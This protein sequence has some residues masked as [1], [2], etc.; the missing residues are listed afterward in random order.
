MQD[1][2]SLMLT[3]AVEILEQL[4]DSEIDRLYGSALKDGEGN[5]LLLNIKTGKLFPRYK[6]EISISDEYASQVFYRHSL[7]SISGLLI[8]YTQSTIDPIQKERA[9]EYLNIYK[10]IEH[11]YNNKKDDLNFDA[12]VQRAAQIIF[13]SLEFSKEKTSS[14]IPNRYIWPVKTTTILD[15]KKLPD[16]KGKRLESI[17][18]RINGYTMKKDV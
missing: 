5:C 1:K 13:S 3:K 8:R 2:N 10:N 16:I 15:I 14:S 11:I 4:S 12:M 17:A 6:R 7:K 18:N 9:E